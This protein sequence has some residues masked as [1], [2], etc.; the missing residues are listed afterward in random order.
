[1]PGSVRE[2]GRDDALHRAVKV[3]TPGRDARAKAWKYFL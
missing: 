2:S 1:M 3:Q